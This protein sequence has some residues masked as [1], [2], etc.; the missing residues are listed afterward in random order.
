MRIPK[1]LSYIQS[2]SLV[3]FLVPD[4]KRMNRRAHLFFPSSMPCIMQPNEISVRVFNA[5]RQGR[6]DLRAEKLLC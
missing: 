5:E 1:I 6:H 4:E 3:F 2:L